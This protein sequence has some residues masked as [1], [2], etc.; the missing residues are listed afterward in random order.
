MDIESHETDNPMLRVGVLPYINAKPLYWTLLNIDPDIQ[1]SQGTPRE[2]STALVN[3]KLD[4]A[5]I[6]LLTVLRNP[7]LSIIPNISISTFGAALNSFVYSKVAAA[8]IKSILVDRSSVTSVAM[9]RAL[10]RIRWSMQPVEVLSSTPMLHDYPFHE[11]DY[12]AYLIIGDESMKVKEEFPYILDLGDK[13]EEWTHLTS[14]FSV[15]AVRENLSG[16]ALDEMFLHVKEE[17]LHSMEEIAE[18]ESAKIGLNTE[19]CLQ[20]L[21]NTIYD[22]GEKELKGLNRF[23][24]YMNSLK[25]CDQDIDLLF[26]QGEHFDTRRLGKK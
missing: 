20:I 11:K 16:P 17:G 21:L 25:I 5:M 1:I 14:I 3:G 15:W 12:D 8:D 24:Y 18:K 22:L 4:V 23:H 26:Y 6:P 7:G 9:L 19:K 10:F 13:W 2:L